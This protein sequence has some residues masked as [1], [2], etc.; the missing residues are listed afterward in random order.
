VLGGGLALYALLA[1]A[2]AGRSRFRLLAW[3]PHYLRWYFWALRRRW[4][5]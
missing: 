5:G 3:L 2:G 4:L 1:M